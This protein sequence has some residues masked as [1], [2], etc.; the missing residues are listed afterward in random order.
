M[1]AQGQAEFVAIEVI[2]LRLP[3]ARGESAPSADS[4]EK[5][6]PA[7]DVDTVAVD[8]LKALD[9]KQPIREADVVHESCYVR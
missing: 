6:E 7:S 1:C 3:R 8:R 2:S 9:S 4:E 5:H